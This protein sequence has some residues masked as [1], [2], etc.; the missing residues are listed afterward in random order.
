[1]ISHVAFHLRT[2]KL[3]F[4]GQL[5]SPLLMQ[6]KNINIA[7]AVLAVEWGYFAKTGK[8]VILAKIVGTQT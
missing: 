2:L 5:L 3:K 1:M 8:K 6:E 7:R 4:H